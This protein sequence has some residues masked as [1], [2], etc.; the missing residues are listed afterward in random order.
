MPDE[1]RDVDAQLTELWETP[2]TV[3][4]WFATVDHKTLGI[5]YLVT[6]VAFLI[7]GGL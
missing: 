5:R 2:K 4:G 3:W 7:I 1:Q 6:A